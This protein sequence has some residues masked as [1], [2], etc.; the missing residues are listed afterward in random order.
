MKWSGTLCLLCFLPLLATAEEPA[1]QLALREA[2][3][4]QL[5]TL[6][7]AGVTRAMPLAEKM[8]TPLGSVWKLYVYAWLED[9]HQPEQ[10]YQ[11]QG[12]DVGEV[13][14]C[15]PGERITRDTALVRSCGLY[16]AP[17]R[18]HIDA[19]AWEAYWRQHNG[20]SWA[21]SL[22]SLQPQTQVGVSAL[23]DSLA[24]LPAQQKARTVLLDVML[25]GT[26]EGLAAALGGRLR[27]KTWSWFSGDETQARR[28][29]FA[30]W[31]TDGTP[32][33]AGGSGT[34][35]T[36][37]MR[38]ASVLDQFLPVSSGVA[39]G[40]CVQ[41]HLFARYPVQSVV[42][43]NTTRSITTG[44]LYGRY[45]VTFSNGNH[46][47]LV[48]NGET[49]LLTEKGV[50]R[51]QAHLDREEYVARVLDREAAATPL[52][53]AKAMTIVIRSYLLQNAQRE[54]DCLVINDSSASQR[55]SPSPASRASREV[56]AWTQDMILAGRAVNYHRDRAATG[57]LSWQMAREQAERGQRVDA[58]LSAAFPDASL[59]RWDDPQATCQPMPEAKRWLVAKMEQWRTQL[60]PEPGYS[61]PP[62][63]AVCKLVSGFPFTDR[64]Q[65]RLY[66]RNFFTLQD[67]LDLAHEYLHLAFD[68][69]PSGLDESYVENLARHLLMD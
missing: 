68:G 36:V 57:L 26:K 33:W 45:R 44:P 69:Y 31:L 1:L 15:H 11:C 8:L 23:L 51:L 67:R 14:C 17:S 49:M 42:K 7:T 12:Q 37:L 18:L 63:F 5:Y 4:N 52:E 38:Y 3:G 6:T 58:I 19:R 40:Q 64:Q 61:E 28:G 29:G 21:L 65:K 27:V 22:S 2:Q 39:S 34:S 30:G 54:G 60:N 25:D 35:K 55:V 56:T 48:S 53:A 66:I 20:P 46:I 24:V 13:Y 41:V 47:S 32:V 50:P 9:T 16:F 62:A 59:S 10:P 43:E